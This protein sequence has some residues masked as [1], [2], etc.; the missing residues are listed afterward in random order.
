MSGVKTV[1]FDADGVLWVGDHLIP[2]AA[3]T[4]DILRE[5]GVTPYVVTNNPT[6]TRHEIA[7]KLMAKGFHNVPEDMIVSAGYVT[8]Q[9]LL[10]IGFDD[11]E[12]RVFKQSSILSHFCRNRRSQR[13]NLHASSDSNH[14]LS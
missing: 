2:G 8:T 14:I 10:S 1:L 13:Y 11:P 7:A 4:M 9:Y 3:E 5:M 12:R 6:N